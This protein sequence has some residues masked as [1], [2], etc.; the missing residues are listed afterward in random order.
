MRFREFSRS[1]RHRG[2]VIQNIGPYQVGAALALSGRNYTVSDGDDFNSA[3][4]IITPGRP[5]GKYAPVRTYQL[6][7]TGQGSRAATGGSITLKVYD[8]DPWHTGFN[9]ANRGNAV[10]SYADS[11]VQAAGRLKLKARRATS[12]EKLTYQDT[13]NLPIQGAIIDSATALY[14]TA[15]F[16][17]ECSMGRLQNNGVSLVHGWHPTFW[18]LQGNI[19]HSWNGREIDFEGNST[20]FYPANYAWSNGSSTSTIGTKVVEASNNGAQRK[21]GL[22]VA[23]DG[24]IYFWLDGTL[25][26]SQTPTGVD[27]TRPFRFIISNHVAD[28]TEDPYSQSDWDAA[29]DNGAILDVDYVMVAR[30]GGSNYSPKL[31]A[32]VQQVNF[33]QAFSIVLPASVDLWGVDVGTNE[34]VEGVQ[35]EVNEPSGN[36]NG[37]WQVLPTG[38]SYNSS[39]RTLSGTISDKSG[40]TIINRIVNVAG[41]TCRPHRIVLQVGPH[42]TV[43]RIANITVGQPYSF[44]L[45]A[46]CDCGALVTDAAGQRAKTISVTGL[47]SGLS[48]NDATGL[49]TGTVSSASAGRIS[50]TIT[51]S[52]GQ[53]TTVQMACVALAAG[54]GVPAPALTG[55]PTLV[56]SLDPDNTGTVTLSGSQ[57]TGLAGTDGTSLALTNGGG[58]GPNRVLASSGRYVADFLGSSSQYL[59]AASASIGGTQIVIF[60]SAGAAL[61]ANTAIFCEDDQAS[62]TTINR[63]Q[64]LK[65]NP[66][67]NGGIVSRRASSTAA[68]DGTSFKGNDTNVHVAI[69]VYG[70]GS[71]PGTLYMDG[72]SGFVNASSVALPSTLTHTTLGARRASNANSLFHTGQVHR[73]LKYAGTLTP[74][75]IAQA[76]DWANLFYGTKNA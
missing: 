43:D 69:G 39:T 48:Y 41:S 38:V 71:A 58:T 23:A 24:K 35:M 8:V 13:A 52:V 21:F 10:A 60:S 3:L 31:P 14:M 2:N 73:V 63:Q 55:S 57:I 28:F 20:G 59:Q 1:A 56:L 11:I 74:Q 49:I 66:D 53:S 25:Y 6:S 18:I 33:G 62:T 72:P 54:S 64:I 5:L 12:A 29:G 19:L 17:V 32:I 22:E 51:N 37:G 67:T 15:P 7:G 61:S 65:L 76:L 27:V 44:D 68:S 30:G 40:Q 42:A 46:V 45:Y 47:P 26:T 50:V 75:Q 4:D 36:I 9:D 16:Y 34:Y 70:S